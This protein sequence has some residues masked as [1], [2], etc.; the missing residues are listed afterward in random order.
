MY[1]LDTGISY[2]I[3]SM[4]SSL[5][6]DPLRPEFSHHLTHRLPHRLY[7]IGVL[8]HICIL[9]RPITI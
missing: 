6:K 8:H 9:A 4:I 1:S 2:S 5:R 7:T 3:Y